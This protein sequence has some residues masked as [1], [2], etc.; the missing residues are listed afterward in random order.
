MAPRKSKA[1]EEMNP[2]LDAI[3]FAAIAQSQEGVTYQTHCRFISNQIIAFNGILAIGVP[4]HNIALPDIC[5]NTFQLIHALERARGSSSVVFEGTG[6]TVKTAKFRAQVPCVEW[7]V[8]DFITPD[9]AAYALTDDF[10]T[11]A[12]RSAIYTREG[13][14]TVVAASVRTRNGSI[15]GTNRNVIVEAWHGCPTPEG[16]I[17]PKSF[18]DAIDKIKKKIHAFGFSA[19]TFTIHY[20][21]GSWIKTQLYIEEWPN[22]DMIFAYL[23]AARRIEVP[24]DFWEGLKSVAPFSLDS[25]VYFEPNLIR[26]HAD[27]KT[28]ASYDV[29]GLPG[30]M[31]FNWKYLAALENLV[32]HIDFDGNTTVACFFGDRLRGVISRSR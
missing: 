6:I 9:P 2:L 10:K 15:I 4:A 32:T 26:S 27:G 22:V 20:D 13:A 16:L 7:N 28:G 12:V 17:I 21:D 29:K 23:D 19:T 30:E 14:Q 31:S 24:K 3:R 11:A 1:N 18:I 25:R 5:P 8:I